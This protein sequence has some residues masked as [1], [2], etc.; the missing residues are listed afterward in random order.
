MCEVTLHSNKDASIAHFSI[1]IPL[2]FFSRLITLV[3]A[4]STVPNRKEWTAYLLVSP[5]L[6]LLND[7]GFCQVLY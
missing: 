5:G 6:L 3:K 1:C 4:S 2:I 7:V